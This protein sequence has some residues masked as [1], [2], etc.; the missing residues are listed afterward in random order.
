[1]AFDRRQMARTMTEL[2]DAHYPVEEFNQDNTRMC[3]ASQ[4]LFELASLGRL[5]HGGDKVL[6]SPLASAADYQRPPLG[7]R[8][9]KADKYDPDC[10]IDGAISTAM[11]AWI[12]QGSGRAKTFAQTGGIR[13]ISLG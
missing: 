7:W 3:A 11:A 10:K 9:A 2:E 12:A 6:A 1:M 13:T 8:F 5:R 4:W